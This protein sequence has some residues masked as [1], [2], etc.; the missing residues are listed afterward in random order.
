MKNDYD[1]C[2]LKVVPDIQA[3]DM[4]TN[5]ERYYK[6]G[7]QRR[8]LKPWAVFLSKK[9]LKKLLR[10]MKTDQNCVELRLGL[11][12]PPHDGLVHAVWMLRPL[13]AEKGDTSNPIQ[14]SKKGDWNVS[15]YPDGLPVEP[16]V[17]KDPADREE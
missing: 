8:D 12:E 14:R 17:M 1:S 2:A 15:I 4:I 11:L 13:H 7:D 5:F 3:N 6:P 10:E 9:Y 16:V